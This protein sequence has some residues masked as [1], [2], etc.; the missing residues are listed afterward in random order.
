MDKISKSSL[1]F[2]N[3]ASAKTNNISNDVTKLN[4]NKNE[5]KIEYVNSFGDAVL[6]AFG[7]NNIT[8]SSA[9]EI[10]EDSYLNFIDKE[11]IEEAIRCGQNSENIKIILKNGDTYLFTPNGSDYILYSFESNGNIA[12]FDNGLSELYDNI[13][14][15]GHWKPDIKNIS[16]YDDTLVITKELGQQI[17]YDTSNNNELLGFGYQGNYY[18]VEEIKK[19]I[20]AYKEKE[21]SELKD[22]LGS[23]LSSQELAS[24]IQYIEDAYSFDKIETFLIEDY[25]VGIELEDIYTFWSVKFEN[26]KATSVVYYD[27]QSPYID[28]HMILDID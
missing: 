13:F 17:Y 16:I 22:S 24:R 27:S 7:S 8:K 3:K 14:F 20:N 18:S 15:D 6:D 1:N 21:I 10:L 28:G 11:D 26:N 9:M 19:G 25:G 5:A 12:T 4:T 2:E 23:F